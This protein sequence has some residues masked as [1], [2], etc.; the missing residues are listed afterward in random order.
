L[1]DEHDENLSVIHIQS[2]KNSQTNES[3]EEANKVVVVVVVNKHVF[4]I[5][6]TTINQI[7]DISFFLFHPVS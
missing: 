3:R 2:R 1:L 5:A 7:F 6:A 4:F